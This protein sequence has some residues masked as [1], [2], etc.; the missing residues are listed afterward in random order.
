MISF[1][2]PTKNEE[3]AIQKTLK[4]IRDNF[5]LV[6]YEIIVSDDDSTDQTVKE[7][8]GLADLVLTHTHI[9]GDTISANRNRGAA[10]AQY[11]YLVFLDS[12]AFIPQLDYFFRKAIS[13]FEQDPKL[14]ALT[15]NLRVTPEIA[16]LA[17]RFFFGCVDLTF[18][19]GNNLLGI[20]GASGKFQ[21]IKKSI[22]EKIGG[23]NEKLVVAE[24]N[25]IF[26]RLARVG[27]TRIEPTL[28]A[29][30]GGRRVH[31]LGWPRVLWSWTKNLLSAI[32][33]KKSVDKEWKPIR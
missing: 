17:D 10:K 19:I 22:F 31:A 16:T 11:P 23:Y 21:M 25:E 27:K 32:V 6:P 8:A 9:D 12:D 14:V 26:W 29:Y 24:D 30:H 5:H 7:A 3:K 28:T 20:G 13:C 2:I 15:V 18:L 1:I 33:F 4:H